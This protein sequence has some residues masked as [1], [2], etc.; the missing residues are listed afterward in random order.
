MALFGA[1]PDRD[2]YRLHHGVAFRIQSRLLEGSTSGRA[3]GDD[4]EDPARPMLD[5][6]HG[7][8]VGPALGALPCG[9][10]LIMSAQARHDLLEPFVFTVNMPGKPGGLAAALAAVR[11][12]DTGITRAVRA[13]GTIPAGFLFHCLIPRQIATINR[14]QA[15]LF[16][17]GDSAKLVTGGD[18][19]QIRSMPSRHTLRYL[20]AAWG[21][22]NP[23]ARSRPGPCP[24]RTEQ[25]SPNT[26][27]PARRR[28]PTRADRERARNPLS[29]PASRAGRPD[30]RKHG[31]KYPSWANR[32]HGQSRQP[33][34][35][36]SPRGRAAPS[37]TV[38]RYDGSG[39]RSLSGAGGNRRERPCC[40]KVKSRARALQVGAR[41]LRPLGRVGA[42]PAPV[43]HLAGGYRSKLEGRRQ[44]G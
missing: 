7:S 3:A 21:Q 1:H 40:R 8:Q 16:Q 34:Q 39:L 9:A 12:V 18:R 2:R 13:V 35:R 37:G 14:I 15:C 29:R 27:A 42:G 4:V 25:P 6:L 10:R 22:D 41:R 24:R 32:D 38:C 43:A 28:R 26:G 17:R 36:R 19:R 20:I 23:F 31:G 30:L 5:R 11:C 33:A 44:R